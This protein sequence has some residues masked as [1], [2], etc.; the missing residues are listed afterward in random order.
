MSIF[1]YA[2]WSIRSVEGN[3]SDRR[4]LYIVRSYGGPRDYSPSVCIQQFVSAL[5]EPPWKSGKSI[6]I[7]II[8]R[9]LSEPARQ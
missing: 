9:G 3:R 8:D 2:Y 4:S 5:Y 1:V 6:G 7:Q